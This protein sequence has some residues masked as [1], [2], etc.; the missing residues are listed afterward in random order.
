MAPSSTAPAANP[1]DPADQ[2]EPD[3]VQ[4]P[5]CVDLDSALLRT[6]IWWEGVLTLVRRSPWLAVL[7]PFW[8]LGGKTALQRAVAARVTVERSG[9]AVPE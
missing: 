1:L 6:D 7:V 3:A 9:V 8:M 2:A 5:L 4:R